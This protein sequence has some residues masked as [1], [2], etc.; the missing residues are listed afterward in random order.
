MINISEHFVLHR[1]LKCAEMLII[2]RKSAWILARRV[3]RSGEER[4]V[5]PDAGSVEFL[6]GLS[7]RIS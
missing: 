7:M 6:V 3:H 4:L 5:L 2:E 1:D